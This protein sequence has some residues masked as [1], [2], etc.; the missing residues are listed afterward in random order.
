MINTHHLAYAVE[1][2]L[3]MEEALRQAGA[4][5]AAHFSRSKRRVFMPV[6]DRT[7]K[8]RQEFHSRALSTCAGG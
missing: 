5:K 1:Q 6:L 8:L 2:A 7:P 3:P 4:G